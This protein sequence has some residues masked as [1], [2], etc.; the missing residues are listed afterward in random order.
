[1]RDAIIINNY[2]SMPDLTLLSRVFK[3]YPQVQAVYLFGS[4]ASGKSHEGSDLDLAIVPRSTDLRSKRLDIL[5]DLARI[6]LCNVDL[7]FLDH[8]D[9]V[10]QYEAVR[11][12]RLIY[13]TDD[14]NR[15]ALYSKVIRQY[16]DF[17]PYLKVQRQAYKRR[18]IGGKA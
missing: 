10:L 13:Q 16:L 17:S 8:P 5:T 9:I 15:G 11:L 7:V 6:G 4:R 18:I 12:N 14:F 1:M 3:K 2:N